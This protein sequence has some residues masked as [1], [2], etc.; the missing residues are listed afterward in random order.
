MTR[1]G[2][3]IIMTSNINGNK[4]GFK[5]EY[6]DIICLVILLVIFF[7]ALFLTHGILLIADVILLA[8]AGAVLGKTIGKM[9]KV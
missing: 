1:E 2:T 9:V 3:T 5:P 8:L 4:N 6:I 7:L